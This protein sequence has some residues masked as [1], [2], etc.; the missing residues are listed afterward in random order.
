MLDCFLFVPIIASFSQ[1]SF[2]SSAEALPSILWCDT[3]L[4]VERSCEHLSNSKPTDASRYWNHGRQSPDIS[5]SDKSNNLR[6]TCTTSSCLHVHVGVDQFSRT[7][8]PYKSDCITE[9]VAL[10]KDVPLTSVKLFFL[11]IIIYTHCCSIPA[12]STC[13]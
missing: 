8:N 13:E 6:C 5:C 10:P 3:I 2:V 12:I 7:E 9:K 11:H 1:H 4:L